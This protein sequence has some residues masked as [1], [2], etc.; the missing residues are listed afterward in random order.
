[1]RSPLAGDG[2]TAA[3][4]QALRPDVVVLVGDAALGTINLVRLSRDALHRWPLVVVLN[5]FDADDPLHRAN[6]SW[7]RD[8]D[9]LA[10]CVSIAELATA[11]RT[12]APAR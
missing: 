10:V 3:L 1:V 5:R 8:T 6:R 12:A 4:V 7:L 2:D 11:V 9:G